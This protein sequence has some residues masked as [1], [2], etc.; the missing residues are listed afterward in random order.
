MS[1][2]KFPSTPF[3]ICLAF[4]ALVSLLSAGLPQI[5]KD[6]YPGTTGSNPTFLI[7]MGGVLYF[8]A[9]DGV[10]GD[11]LW[12]TDGTSAG[13]I[14]VKDIYSGSQ[15]SDLSGIIAANNTLYFRA[16]DSPNGGELRKSDGTSAGTVLVKNIG[17]GFI[18]GG[19]EFLTEMG[20]IIYFRAYQ[21]TT[22]TE[23]WRSDGT[24]D[25]TVLVKDVNPGAG[26]GGIDNLTVVGNTLY[27]TAYSPT[28]G[29]E[30][31]KTNGT[32]EGTVLVKDIVAGTG[33]SNPAQ[34]K[35]GDDLLFF[36][37]NDG[38]HG[39]EMWRT[40]GT[41]AGTFMPLDAFPGDVGGS[42]THAATFNGLLYYRCRGDS[43]GDELWISDGTPG[44]TQLFK[45]IN[46]TSTSTPSY[47]TVVG[48]KIYFIA[49][50]GIH[51]VEPWVSDGTV[52]GTVL[53]KDV[54]P[55]SGSGGLFPTVFASSGTTRVYFTA[56]DG[57][58][59]TEL[60]TSNGTEAGTLLVADLTP[61]ATGSTINNLRKAGGKLYFTHTT[62]ATGNELYSL[63]LP[64][65]LPEWREFHFG[66][67]ANSGEG[68]NLLDHDKD[69]LANLVEYA[70]GQDPTKAQPY[71]L[72]IPQL[73]GGS[74]EV[75]FAQPDGV[76]GVTYG[77]E[78]ST[79]L[80][81]ENWTSILDTG[82][83]GIH[84][85]S[86]PTAGQNRIFLRYRVTTP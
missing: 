4:L 40:D 47:L 37:A 18:G 76:S 31:W 66:T 16:L 53:L 58:S 5:V 12:K 1:A 75:S 60:W 71:P 82:S 52:S 74:Y 25:G 46:A 68:A 29:V 32:A 65:T 23:L 51:G 55:G 43:E 83:G 7:E 64:M 20:G 35:A 84:T 45:E 24:A 27:F 77:A 86:V 73:N 78:W 42:M 79:T 67:S 59:G 56:N 28:A 15:G 36:Q 38:V 61:G 14:L 41:E 39:P 48:N 30:L 21:E 9:A 8:R 34:L 13:T 17:P 11:E 69:G 57:N 50:D 19:A 44:G 10:N 72:P 26:S 33:G 6:L 3:A 63:Q 81:A 62:A 54:N 80:T 70:F 49:N 22:G 2:K 85:F